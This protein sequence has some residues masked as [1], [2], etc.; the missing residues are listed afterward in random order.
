MPMVYSYM[1]IK[2]DR[3]AYLKHFSIENRQ[4]I[5][6]IYLWAVQLKSGIQK[7][8]SLHYICIG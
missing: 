4:T 7:S 5:K 2:D 1:V 8:F 6:I 3:N